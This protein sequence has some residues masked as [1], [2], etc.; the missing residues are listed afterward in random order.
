MGMGVGMRTAEPLPLTYLQSH[1]IQFL[2]SASSYNSLVDQ[3]YKFRC[4][5]PAQVK[6]R[7]KPVNVYEVCASSCS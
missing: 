6:G 1:Q 2:C 3:N 5:G 7:P 4:L